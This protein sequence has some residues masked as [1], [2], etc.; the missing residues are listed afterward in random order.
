MSASDRDLT[1]PSVLMMLLPLARSLVLGYDESSTAYF[2][3][4]H[5]CHERFSA[6][7]MYKTQWEGEFREADEK[8]GAL[9]ASVV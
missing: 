8:L 3:Q 9:R 5:H 7:P 6:E 4:C 2:I 1:V